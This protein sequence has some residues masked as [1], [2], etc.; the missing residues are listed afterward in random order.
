MTRSPRALA[1]VDGQGYIRTGNTRWAANIERNPEV[2]LRIA[3]A[4]YLLRVE[5][6]EDEVLRERIVQAFRDKRGFTDTLVALFRTRHP[7][8]M[9]LVA[10]E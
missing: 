3:E 4:E 1:V 5:H 9:R 7:N 6:V 8:I 10:R 2:V